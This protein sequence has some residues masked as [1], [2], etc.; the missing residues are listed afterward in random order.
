MDN[1]DINSV[2]PVVFYIFILHGL[3]HALTILQLM[4]SQYKITD[5]IYLVHCWRGKVR[6]M[7]EEI[8]LRLNSEWQRALCFE[9]AQTLSVSLCNQWF[10]VTWVMHELAHPFLVVLLPCCQLCHALATHTDTKL[11]TKGKAFLWTLEM[12]DFRAGHFTQ[13]TSGAC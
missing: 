13:F 3:G 5:S 8:G 9:V 12:A 7:E 2:S 11:K 10:V 4:W 1:A 6:W